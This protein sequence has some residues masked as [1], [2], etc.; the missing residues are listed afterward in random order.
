[1]RGTPYK[2]ILEQILQK[3]KK[4]REILIN[5]NTELVQFPHAA[6]SVARGTKVSF[7]L[8]RVQ[9][10]NFIRLQ[11]VQELFPQRSDFAQAAFRLYPIT[12][13]TESYIGF[14]RHCVKSSKVVLKCGRVTTMTRSTCTRDFAVCPVFLLNFMLFQIIH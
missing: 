7:N 5:E 2:T 1:M 6:E 4:Q 8:I 13:W 3:K 11:V 12:H 14:F 9:S 10:A